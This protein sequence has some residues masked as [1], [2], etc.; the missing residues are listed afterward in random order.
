MVAVAVNGE[1]SCSIHMKFNSETLKCHAN[2][3]QKA[4]LEFPET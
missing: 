1:Q 4:V 2:F 3:K